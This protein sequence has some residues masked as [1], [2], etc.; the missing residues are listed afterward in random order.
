MGYYAPSSIPYH[1]A[2]ATSF[3]LCDNYFQGVL[4]STASNR[5]M[6]MSG[7]I[8]AQGIYNGPLTGDPLGPSTPSTQIYEWKSYPQQLYDNRYYSFAIYEE[9]PASQPGPAPAKP[10]K[11]NPHPPS[12]KWTMNLAAYFKGWSA[13]VSDSKAKKRPISRTGA[14][15]FETDCANDTLPKVSWII[16]PYHYS[17]HPDYSPLAGEYWLAKKIGA[18]LKHRWADTAVI[19]TYDECGACFDHVCPPLPPATDKDEWIAKGKYIHCSAGPGFRVPCILISPWSTGGRVASQ[20]FDHTSV[21]KFL[22]SFTDIAPAN[23]G[24]WRMG[25]FGNLIDAFGFASPAVA[26]PPVLPTAPKVTWTTTGSVG[27]PVLPQ[28]WPPPAPPLAPPPLAP[29]QAERLTPTLIKR[30]RQRR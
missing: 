29:P 11:T 2:L 14:S 13:M 12:G 18:V 20:L 21:L 24:A 23:I 17:E 30:T 4:S 1:T 6:L 10:T 8:D 9:D 27:L 19:V 3:T 25:K 15:D 7:S 28:R 22:G 16:P 26:T 5:A